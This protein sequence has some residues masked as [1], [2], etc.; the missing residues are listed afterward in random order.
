MKFSKRLEINIKDDIIL[1]IPDEQK[2]EEINLSWEEVWNRAVASDTNIEVIKKNIEQQEYLAEGLS[3][4]ELPTVNLYGKV[5]W[6]KE[7]F[8]S[9]YQIGLNLSYNFNT[10]NNK[11]K[12]LEITGIE[13]GIQSLKEELKN[14]RNGLKL[15]SI[16]LIEN[17]KTIKK[18]I[19]YSREAI[20]LTRQKLEIAEI[21][22]K[23]GVATL[24]EL[25]NYQIE[26][27]ERKSAYITELTNYYK[28][29]YSI[30]L[31]IG[32]FPE[33]EDM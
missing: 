27:R 24:S 6:D 21:R 4:M 33:G 13:N 31:L 8:P 32:E 19:G 23:T 2:L 1:N 17:Q 22:Y 5:F 15:E 14:R 9:D 10:Y 11:S 16:D 3:G 7:E 20:E 28:N 30:K 29:L 26:L 18:Q 12:G 25:L